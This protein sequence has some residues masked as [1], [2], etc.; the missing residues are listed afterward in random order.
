MPTRLAA[1]GIRFSVLEDEP[2]PAW[3][4]TKLHFGDDAATLLL[5]QR[6][7]E[8]LGDLHRRHGFDLI[9]FPDWGAL[10]FRCIQ[11]KRAGLA[12]QDVPLAVK[13]DSTTQWQREGNLLPRSTPR[14]L[15]MEFCERYAFERADV[16]L[17]PSRYMVEWSRGVDWA[18]RDDVEVA[19]PFPDP[20]RCPPSRCPKSASSR[21][22]DGSSGARGCIC[23]S[24]RWTRWRSGCRSCSW[25]R[26]R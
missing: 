21:S 15:K 18:V 11:A 10:G 5:S 24:T 2:E 6:V 17:S 20:S 14:D 7:L 19:S 8:A 26:T 25:A 22:S 23:S 4:K 9:E 13:L 12:F 1:D 16:Q 3:V